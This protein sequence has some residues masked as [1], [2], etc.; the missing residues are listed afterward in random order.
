MPQEATP[1]SF[2]FLI[3]TPPGSSAPG[4]AVTIWSPA[5]KFWAPHTTVMGW[6]FPSS[7]TLQAPTSTVHTHMWSESGCASLASTCAVT[8]CSK[9]APSVSTASTPVP[10]RSS[11]SQKAFRLLGTSTY[12]ERHFKDTFIC[13]SLSCT[14]ARPPPGLNARREGQRGR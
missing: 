12:S 11:R 2:D 4:S 14:S 5:S 7:S 8:T 1:R 10:V 3:F 13:P 9:V 6:G